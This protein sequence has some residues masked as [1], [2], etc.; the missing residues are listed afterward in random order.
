MIRKFILSL[1][2]LT[3]LGASAATKYNEYFNVDPNPVVIGSNGMGEVIVWFNTEYDMVNG[4]QM[5]VYL[6]EG[7][8]IEQNKRTGTYLV[9]FYNGDTEDS[10]TY[11]H[12]STVGHNQD[13]DGN[14]YYRI[15]GVSMNA[16]WVL[17]GYHA[18][19]HY[20][21][22]APEGFID[23]AEA[24]VTNIVVGGVTADPVS[25]HPDDFTFEISDDSATT[26]VEQISVDNFVGDDVIYDLNGR[27]VNNT[28]APGIY[29]VNGE[30]RIIR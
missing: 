23:S 9:N 5:D 14:W 21:I 22:I 27:R 8:E 13:A 15:I 19:F 30:K 12:T 1:I 16:I 10:V 4:F 26:G 24:H 18:L 28:T 3:V 7:F 25:R 17:P 29:I 6:P 2:S 20:N 11:D